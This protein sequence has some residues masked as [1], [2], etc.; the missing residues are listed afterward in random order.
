MESDNGIYNRYTRLHIA[1]TTLDQ[2]LD[3][4]RS[5]APDGL[6]AAKSVSTLYRIIDNNKALMQLRQSSKEKSMK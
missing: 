6:S 1:T 3:Y 4:V 5:T 2:L